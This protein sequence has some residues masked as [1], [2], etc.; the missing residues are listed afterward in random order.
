MKEENKIENENKIEE[1]NKPEEPKKLTETES[2]KSVENSSPLPLNCTWTFW[3]ASRKEKDHHIPY[4]DRLTKIA[5]FSALQ[6]FF[7]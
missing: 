1:P 3:Y 7:K 6:D 4:S 5:E 2:N